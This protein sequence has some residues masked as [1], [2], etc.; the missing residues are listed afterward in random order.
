MA[1]SVRCEIV[2]HP[3]GGHK[4]FRELFLLQAHKKTLLVEF[5]ISLTALTTP[6]L[7]SVGLVSVPIGTRTETLVVLIFVFI[8]NSLKRNGGSIAHRSSLRR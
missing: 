7:L 5:I 3:V 6:S 4:V 1:F 2:L 8:I